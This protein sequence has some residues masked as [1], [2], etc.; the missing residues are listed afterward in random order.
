MRSTTH[1]G[2]FWFNVVA[3][4]TFT[5]SVLM[6]MHTHSRLDKD[7]IIYG[8]PAGERP[9]YLAGRRNGHRGEPAILSRIDDSILGQQCQILRTRGRW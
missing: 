4:Q 9:V 5:N 7:N 2:V 1:T 3:I 6:I 8:W